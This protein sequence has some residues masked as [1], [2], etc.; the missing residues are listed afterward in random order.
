[1]ARFDL[2]IFD[3]DGVLVDSEPIANRML[4]E[5]LRGYGLDVD[6]LDCVER[7]LGSTLTRVR[8]LVEADLGH[9]IPADFEERYREAVYPALAEQVTAVPGVAAVLDQLDDRGTLT[10][11]ASSGLH[12]RIRLTLA[13]AGLL[14]RFGDRLFSAEDVGVG[15]PA[16]DL[17][18][19]AADRLGVDPA[20]CAVIEDAPAGV[21]AAHAAAMTVFGY[22]ALTP[23]RFVEHANG[24][25]FADMGELPDLLAGP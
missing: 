21:D 19:H 12:R 25:V 2:V 23:R 8:A 1:M 16:P 6:W 10:C 17:F 5:Q 7:Y 9:A 15:K 14:E 11:V 20:R 24:G 3:N 22:V 13:R 4:A 18:L